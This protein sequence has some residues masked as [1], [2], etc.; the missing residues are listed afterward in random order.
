MYPA[1][2]KLQMVGG[3]Q[4]WLPAQQSGRVVG[5]AQPQIGLEMIENKLWCVGGCG[6][7]Y[8]RRQTKLGAVALPIA[9]ALP[10][11][12]IELTSFA[13]EQNSRNARCTN[14]DS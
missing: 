12:G 7:R 8:S 1:Q 6:D 14:I 13:V 2:R 3:L 5:N 10:V 9:V 4:G 11:D